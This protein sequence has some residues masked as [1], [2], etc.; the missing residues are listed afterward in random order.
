[1]KAI[2]MA[3]GEGKRLRPLTETLPKPLLPVANTPAIVHI[4]RLLKKHGITDAVITTGYLASKIESSLGNSCE[5]VNLTYKK[6]EEPLGTAGGVKAA[7]DHIGD[8]DFVVISGDCISETD[9][10]SAIKVRKEKDAAVLMILS[11]CD[12][13][14]EY[15]VV[16][17]DENGDISRFCEKP[18]LSSTYSSRIN[19]GIYVMSPR[20][21]DYIPD[22]KSDF[23]SD[24]FPLMMKKGERISS[25]IDSSYWCDIGDFHSYRMANLLY[26]GGGIVKGEDCQIESHDIYGSVLFDRVMVGK[27][28]KIENSIIASDVHIGKNVRIEENCVIGEGCV[29]E[30]GAVVGAG[31]LIGS[32]SR[33]LENEY[34][35]HGSGGDEKLKAIYDSGIRCP[36]IEMGP[37]FCVKLGRALCHTVKKGRIGIMTDG[38]NEGQRIAL[39]ILRG[40]GDSGGETVLLGNGFEAAAAL[41][42]VKLSLDLSLFVRSEGNECI[43][44]FFDEN[45]LYPKRSFERGLFSAM[46]EQAAD[47][48]AK[49]GRLSHVD[50]IKSYYLPAMTSGRCPLEGFE[51]TVKRRNASSEFLKEAIMLLGGRVTDNGVKL[52]VS[53]DGFTLTVDDGSVIL[54]DWHVKALLL[55]YLIRDRVSLPII[56]PSAITDICQKS[57]MLYTHCPSGDGEDSARQ[58]AHSYPELIHGIAA[59]AELAGLLSATNK[60]LKELLRHLPSFAMSSALFRT[61]DKLRFSVLSSLGTPSGDGVLSEYSSGSVR[62]IP[63]RDGFTL[64]SEAASGE[65]AEELIALSEKE[66]I[67]NLEKA[68]KKKN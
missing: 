68:N 37:S 58:K 25:V 11:E 20:V 30:D 53:D 35:R 57:P 13:P 15:G 60:E 39:A 67:Y 66:I 40:I 48:T 16:L 24:V 33:I 27:G 32:G 46:K 8:D 49:K 61:K 56:S 54:D 17:T 6:E 12:E 38:S 55:R 45:G 65:Y 64:I 31:S 47:G 22:G 10:S 42:A 1:M 9:L 18:S 34:V 23:S 62:I 21:F 50:F 26:N 44:S 59:A 51:I 28:T 63:R 36:L 3:G 2:I 7:M 14:G 5:G 29:I 41:A 19:T 4:I 43:I 52:S